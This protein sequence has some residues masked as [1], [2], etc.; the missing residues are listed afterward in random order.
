MENQGRSHLNRDEVVLVDESAKLPS[1]S[2]KILESES[3]RNI[4]SDWPEFPPV[5][6]DRVEEAEGENQLFVNFRLL[7]FFQDAV[8]ELRIGPHQVRAHALRRFIRHLHAVLQKQSRE[9]RRRH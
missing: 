3:V 8:V 4:P 6:A 9:R 5:L 7:A 1:A 2:H